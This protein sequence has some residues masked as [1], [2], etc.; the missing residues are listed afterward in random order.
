MIIKR[1]Q[2]S[3][4][5]WL[6]VLVVS[7]FAQQPS[8]TPSVDRLQQI[9]GY[10]ASDALEGR[11]T[12]TKGANDA[13]NYIAG[14]FKRL[15][16]RPATQTATQRPA[17]SAN[18]YLQ[19]FPYVSSVEL[20]KNNS[21][22]VVTHGVS[23]VPNG[24]LQETLQVGVDWMPLGFSTN[25]TVQSNGIIFS[26]YGISS[27]ELKHDDYQISSPK[28]RIA[29]IF[30]GTPDGDNPHGQ[31]AQAGQLRFKAAAARAAGARALIIISRE[32]KL[33]DDRLSRLT[34][35]NAGEAGLPIIV[36]SRKVGTS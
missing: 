22:I 33:S 11:R 28:N 1:R 19:S 18:R 6:L 32:E 10:L 7:G 27:A 30:D 3:S 15:G 26:G 9:I 2:F 8:S 5:L 23:D 20:G 13:A 24:I 35:D 16:L 25:G 31:F 29:I 21:L 17:A 34:Y 14:E 4:L 36:V 12:G